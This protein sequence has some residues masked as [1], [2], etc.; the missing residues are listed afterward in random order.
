M[1]IKQ[2]DTTFVCHCGGRIMAQT[3]EREVGE[4]EHVGLGLHGFHC[5]ECGIQYSRTVMEPRWGEVIRA[6]RE[7]EELSKQ[8]VYK[9]E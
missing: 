7:L 9:E 1:K 5:E 6:Q 2:H 4:V 3:G 8:G